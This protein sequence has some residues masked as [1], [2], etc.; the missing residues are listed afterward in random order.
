ME[1]KRWG[2]VKRMLHKHGMTIQYSSFSVALNIWLVFLK[3]TATPQGCKLIKNY[4]CSCMKVSNSKE[5]CYCMAFYRILIKRSRLQHGCLCQ[6][7]ETWFVATIT[8]QNKKRES[9]IMWF[10]M[11]QFL[12]VWFDK[13]KKNVIYILKN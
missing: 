7:Y 6:T 3:K 2:I 11:E 13:K 1:Q 9:L 8:R 12:E 10:R 4:Q 5:K